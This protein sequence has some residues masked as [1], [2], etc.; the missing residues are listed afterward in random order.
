MWMARP[1]ERLTRVAGR[2]EA[3]DIEARAAGSGGGREVTALAQT[4][5]RLAAALR[6]QDELRRAT[7]ADVTHELRNALVGVVARIETLQDGV[8]GDERAVLERMERDARRVHHLVDDI[9]LLVAAQRPS[10][11][12]DTRDVD[13]SDVVGAAVERHEDSF[14]AR[15]IALSAAVAPVSVP[16]DAGRLG[17]VLDNLLS[18]AARYTNPGGTVH[19]RLV[20]RGDRAAIEVADSGI[21]IAP[22]HLARV[23]DRFFRARAAAERVPEGSGVG[24]AI[25][26]EIVA[27]HGGRIDVD[28]RPGEG[29]TFTVLLPAPPS[30]PG[31]PGTRAATRARVSLRA[32]ARA[33]DPASA[34]H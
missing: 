20:R 28:S 33:A 29:S 26:S 12:V 21:G 19:V 13:L 1:L 8:A 5:D 30:A 3:G 24:L 14:R 32:P 23:F 18:N 22:E 2:M 7:A 6:R 16:G 34:A 27:A 11:L 10:L 9:G 15:S 25:V 31:N 17:Q 4:M